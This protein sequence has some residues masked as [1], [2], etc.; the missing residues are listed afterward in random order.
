MGR[1]AILHTSPWAAIHNCRQ[2]V[3]G[4]AASS[5]QPACFRIERSI[6]TSRNTSRRPGRRDRPRHRRGGRW[7]I[8]RAGPPRPA[9]GGCRRGR[10]G[11]PP[12]RVRGAR[13]RSGR[14]RAGGAPFRNAKRNGLWP[15]RKSLP[16]EFRVCLLASAWRRIRMA[17]SG[18]EVPSC[19]PA[20]VSLSHLL[21][22]ALGFDSAHRKARRVQ[23]GCEASTSQPFLVSVI[24]A[25]TVRMN[26]KSIRTPGTKRA[27]LG[28]FS[29]ET[30]WCP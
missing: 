29:T 9:S 17:T 2:Y 23:E 28:V 26:L 22:P 24:P 7:R 4:E 18:Y 10:T 25:T 15:R 3:A 27:G 19:L 14:S 12:G 11:R 13:C 8:R 5:P 6:S 1:I 30:P 21:V 16:E 20:P